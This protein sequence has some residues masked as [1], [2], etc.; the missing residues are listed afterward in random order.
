MGGGDRRGRVG[1]PRARCPERRHAADRDGVAEA[2]ALQPV[3]KRGVRAIVGIDHHPGD[4]E[5]G[6]QDGAHLRE[7]DA[8][9]LAELQRLRNAHGRASRRIRGPRRRHVQLERQRPGA[10][11]GDQRTRHGDLAIADLAQS[12]EFT[13]VW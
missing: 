6:F 10:P 13:L 1:P 3:A 11:V 7:R 12:Q 4:R 2:E 5:A 8:P 9:F